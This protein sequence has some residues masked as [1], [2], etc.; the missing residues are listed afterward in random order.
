M[1]EAP[2]EPSLP[3]RFPALRLLDRQPRRKGF[4]FIQQL[5]TTDCGAAC[6][7]MVLGYHGREVGL[8]EAREALAAGRDGVSVLDLLATA[9]S[10]GLRGRGI[11][12]ELEDL[13]HLQPGTILHWDMAHFVVFENITRRDVS[14]LDPALGRRKLTLAEVGR[15]F[16]GVA[17]ELEPAR[18]FVPATRHLRPLRRYVQMILGRGHL[19]R[20]IAVTSL[21][22][23]GLAVAIPLFTGALIDQVIPNADYG[24]LLVLCL[25]ILALTVFGYVT[26]LVRGYLMLQ[27]RAELDVKMSM[28]LIEHLVRLPFSFFQTRQ[29]GDLMLRLSSTTYIR[30]IL[31]SSTASIALDGAMILGYL[32]VLFLLHPIMGGL[33]LILAATR[34]LVF[35]AIRRAN[36]RLMAENLQ[37]QAASSSYQVQ[38]I[39]GIETLKSSGAEGRAVQHWSQLFAK[40]MTNSI[41]RERLNLTSDATLKALAMISPALVLGYGSYLVLGQKMSLGTMLAI[42]ALVAGVLGPL[43]TL[44]SSAMQLQLLGSYVE[45]VEDVLQTP[46]EQTQDRPRPAPQVR[47]RVRLDRVSFRYSPSE[48][49]AVRDVSL[50][51]RPGQLVAVVGRSGSGKSTLARLLVGLYLPS[52]G[53]V[54]L[55][56][57]PLSECDLVAVRRQVGFVPQVPHFFDAS[58]RDNISLADPR[59]TLD[60]I[61]RAARAARIHDEVQAMPLGYETMLVS[62]GGSISGGQRQRVAL[63][64]ALLTQPKLLILDEATSHL[65]GTTEH[66]VYESLADLRGTRVIIAHRLSTIAQAESIFV[67]KEGRIVEQGTHHDLVQRGGPYA[68]L[69]LDQ[70]R[71]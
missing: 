13:Q 23:Q 15:H 36:A 55:D 31:T 71:T 41:D 27:L 33:V 20:R 45:R 39:Q 53:S 37:A 56:D 35:L 26:Q 67:M 54:Y 28:D 17:L 47:G 51:I 8:D 9:E 16:T 29:T 3:E 30:E 50:E 46:S 38:M 6:L 44:I 25:G 43:T 49:F 40:L 69:V 10:F 61:E 32:L 11:R 19:L 18:E 2:P 62:A 65:D 64:R 14:I 59:A 70:V 5:Q 1:A 34:M 63:A 52:E 68:G 42:S 22:L 58:I 24:L 60:D 12:L 66:Q 21:F 7:A 57:M 4:P 48:P